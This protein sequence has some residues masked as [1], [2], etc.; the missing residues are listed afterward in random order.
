MG[1]CRNHDPAAACAQ[2]SVIINDKEII[3]C[4][5]AHPLSPCPASVHGTSEKDSC[6]IIGNSDQ[7]EQSDITVSHTQQRRR[8]HVHALLPVAGQDNL[9]LVKSSAPIHRAHQA[10]IRIGM[11][12]RVIP[13]EATVDKY[14]AVF[15]RLQKSP[16]AVPGIPRLHIRPKIQHHLAQF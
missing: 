2:N 4:T 11:I 10:Q 14:N 15:L 1:R 8:H 7:I 3:I 9:S 6:D 16:L 5:A 12:R 13:P